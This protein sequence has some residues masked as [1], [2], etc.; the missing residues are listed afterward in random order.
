VAEI[1]GRLEAPAAVFNPTSWPRSEVIEL[2]W[3]SG[4]LLP[5]SLPAEAQALGPNSVAAWVEA[6]PPVGYA[7]LAGPPAPAAPAAAAATG[8]LV[9][10]SN[11]LVSATLDASQGGVI[12]HLSL[13]GETNL[14]GAGADE[15]VF[16]ADTGD[17]YG[18]R[19]G[20]VVA[21]E[22]QAPAIVSVLA[23]GPLLA[24]AQAAFV[25]AGQP[26]T[27]TVTV[28][29]GAPLVEVTLELRALPESSA[30]LQIATALQPAARTDDLG[31]Q[32]FTHVFDAGPIVP[33]DVTYRRQIFYPFMYWSDVSAGGRGLT[34][35]THGLQGLAGMP[36][37]NL[38]LARQVTD[39][40]GEGVTDQ[41]L[42]RL[43]YAYLPHAGD[44]G[45]ERAWQA[46]YAF[47]QPLIP[48]WRAGGQ[49]WVQ[50]PFAGGARPLPAPP[51]GAAPFP[52]AHSLLEAT[53]GLVVDLYRRHGQVEALLLPYGLGAPVRLVSGGQER[54]A[55]GPAPLSLALDLALP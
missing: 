22:T 50:V 7:P 1:M 55:A 34:L 40:D 48:A 27:K 44:A 28:R 17:V 35:I 11:G 36:L 18:A 38:L 19:F 2:S 23:E 31:F 4:S 5:A 24:R 33:G 47:N 6:A 41:A 10:L 13:A 16:R 21:R 49:V 14:L 52:A 51:S 26:I 43:R 12:T 8:D 46:A 45:T 39:E 25:L 9:T 29:A 37:L 54:L 3:P 42:H 20:E 15:V 53:G 30:L 32:A